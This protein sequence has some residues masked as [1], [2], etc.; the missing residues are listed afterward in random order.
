MKTFTLLLALILTGASAS[1]HAQTNAPVAPTDEARAQATLDKH[2]NPILAALN[3]NDAKKESVVKAALA[4][5]LGEL[6][7][8]HK[9]NDTQ[10]K[11]AWAGFNTAHGKRDEV[12]TEAA[13]AKIND[14]YASF[15]PA[16]DK[17]IT[18]L[19][20]VLTPEQ[21]ETV[22]DTLSIN[23]VKITYNVYQQIFPNLT[24][25][26]NAFILKNLKQAREDSL[27]AAAMTDKSAFFKE[28]KTK[29][30]AY[31]T[32]QGYDVKQ[33]YKDFGAKQKAAM[34]DKQKPPPINDFGGVG[35]D[36]RS[37]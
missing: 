32:A 25:E 30:E 6:D 21:V 37:L 9:Q 29:I 15:Q 7:A 28:Y 5:Y 16:H 36:V 27:N 8:W 33:A 4:E 19:S 20:T 12:A 11:A 18:Q 23:K 1:L 14:T 24:P 35:D 10:A 2:A 3:L 34:A 31:L 26:Q 22:E 17:F 13:D